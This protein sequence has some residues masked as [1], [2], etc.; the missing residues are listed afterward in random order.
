MKKLKKRWRFPRDQ[1]N[2]YTSNP[3]Q[4]K[5]PSAQG[6]EGCSV[7]QVPEGKSFISEAPPANWNRVILDYWWEKR[8][9]DTPTY[10]VTMLD[11]PMLPENIVDQVVFDSV[12][13]TLLI[14]ASTGAFGI[15][16]G[17]ALYGKVLLTT[18]PDFGVEYDFKPMEQPS[19]PEGFSD[20]DMLV[21][22]LSGNMSLEE[23]VKWMLGNNLSVDENHAEPLIR[24]QLPH[25]NTTS[26]NGSLEGTEYQEIKAPT[27][28]RKPTPLPAPPES[29]LGEPSGYYMQP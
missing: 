7:N 19:V 3:N 10:N 12:V 11:G 1:R 21:D 8:K 4:L 27:G 16:F 24:R 17:I 23:K 26:G 29:I 5:K 20:H 6:W 13:G 25:S 18:L 2:R 14:G 15:F 28:V 9:L 22:Y